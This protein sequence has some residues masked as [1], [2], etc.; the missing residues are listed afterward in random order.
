VLMPLHTNLLH[1]LAADAGAKSAAGWPGWL[2]DKVV[3]RNFSELKGFSVAAVGAAQLLG[4]MLDRQLGY[5]M[6]F[7][8]A[9]NDEQALALLRED[10]VQAVFTLGGWPLPTVSRLKAGHGIHLVQF[11]LEPRA[12]YLSNKR[13]YQNLDAYNMNFLG[14]PNVL[15]TRPFKSGGSMAGKVAALQ[16]CLRNRLDELQEGR[17]HPAWKEIKDVEERYGLS[18]LAARATTGSK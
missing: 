3:I 1:V 6:R 18:G 12:P 4:Q 15:V 8:A 11:N 2:A 17:Y 7:V 16:A 14:V 5:G 10:R 9:D 13:N